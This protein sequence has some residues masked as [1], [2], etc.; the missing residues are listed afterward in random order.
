VYLEPR[1]HEDREFGGLFI[2][3]VLQAYQPEHLARLL[4]ERNES[5]FVPVIGMR[6]LANLGGSE[7]GNAREKPQ[8]QIFGTDIG[9]E[10]GV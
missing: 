9:E 3:L 4:V 5:H 8:P 7:F 1:A 6:E 10:R 2:E